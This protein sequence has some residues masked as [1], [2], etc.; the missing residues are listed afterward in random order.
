MKLAA[1]SEATCQLADGKPPETTN[2][3]DCKATSSI[4]WIAGF[5]TNG[6]ALR[7]S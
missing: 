2:A 4:I 6:G 1:P 5:A 7:R 3:C